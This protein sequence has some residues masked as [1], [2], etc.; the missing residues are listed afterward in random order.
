MMLSVLW[1]LKPG[2]TAA[3]VNE[4]KLLETSLV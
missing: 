4:A 2:F 3:Q 1:F